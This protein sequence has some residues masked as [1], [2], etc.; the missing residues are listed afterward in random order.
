MIRLTCPE[1]IKKHIGNPT[2]FPICFKGKYVIFAAYLQME[3]VFAY[4]LY[5]TI[6]YNHGK[7][8][9]ATAFIG[10]GNRL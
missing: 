5:E 2:G 1:V 3:G 7:A 10:S 4:T 6:L 8:M 9:G